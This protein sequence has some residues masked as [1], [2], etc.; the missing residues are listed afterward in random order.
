M[1]EATL[2][3]EYQRIKNF[4]GFRRG[5]LPNKKEN[6]ASDKMVFLSGRAT[7]N[8]DPERKRP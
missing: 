5:G 3:Q 7:R 2:K 8:L 1:E 4:Q 6:I